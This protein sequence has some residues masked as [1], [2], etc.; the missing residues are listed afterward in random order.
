EAGPGEERG[1]GRDGNDERDE[2]WQKEEQR[3]R[4]ATWS[5]RARIG[6]PSGEGEPDGQ[7]RAQRGR[8]ERR[9]RAPAEREPGHAQNDDEDQGGGERK[10][11]RGHQAWAGERGVA[12]NGPGRRAGQIGRA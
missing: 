5:E 1:A 12:Q 3:P 11:H 7:E 2:A 8:V 6:V 4:P 9:E 10:A